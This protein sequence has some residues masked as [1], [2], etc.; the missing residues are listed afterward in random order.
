MNVQNDQ[1]QM[2]AAAVTQMSAA[3]D[4]VARSADA[5]STASSSAESTVRLGRAS[6]QRNQVR[7]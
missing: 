4:E 3:V 6:S 2:A 1:M 5:T 7:D